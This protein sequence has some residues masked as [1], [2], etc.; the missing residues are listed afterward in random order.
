MKNVKNWIQNSGDCKEN[1]CVYVYVEYDFGVGNEG[2]NQCLFYI[3][4]VQI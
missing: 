3:W 2:F 1:I 4:C